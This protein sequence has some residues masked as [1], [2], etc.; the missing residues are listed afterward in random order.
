MFLSPPPSIHPSI[1]PSLS[2]LRPPHPTPPHPQLFLALRPSLPATHTH[3][4][5]SAHTLQRARTRPRAHRMSGTCDT[6]IWCAITS[7]RLRD[8]ASPGPAMSLRHTLPGVCVRAR[9]RAR[10]CEC[11]SGWVGV[12]HVLAPHPAMC[13]RAC[14]RA[15]ERAHV[16][17]G[18][19]V[20]VRACARAR[21]GYSCATPCRQRTWVDGRVGVG[22]RWEVTLPLS[23]LP[24]SSFL[25]APSQCRAHWPGTCSRSSACCLIRTPPQHTHSKTHSG[26]G[27]RVRGC[28]RACM[29]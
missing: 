9:S 16:R 4:H 6:P 23:S 7:P 11:V 10:V 13:V 26:A 18:L 25:P 24:P 27:G 5:S 8:M 12:C 14:E 29:R 1:H 2:P 21:P 17:V 3:S 22:E 19:F 20:H 15:S 28:V